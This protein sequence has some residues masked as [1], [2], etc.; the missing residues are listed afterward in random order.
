MAFLDSNRVYE[1][2][3]YRSLEK[4]KRI[5]CISRSD[6]MTLR[7]YPSGSFCLTRYGRYAPRAYVV[8]ADCL[9]RCGGIA[10]VW[11]ILDVQM[12]PGIRDEWGMYEAAPLS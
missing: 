10:F 4:C 3:A 12:T 7:C 1:G 2:R 11:C 5:M 6:S 8:V 9:I